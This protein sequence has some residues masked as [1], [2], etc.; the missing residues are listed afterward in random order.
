LS[1]F[2]AFILQEKTANGNWDSFHVL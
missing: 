2:G 1:Y